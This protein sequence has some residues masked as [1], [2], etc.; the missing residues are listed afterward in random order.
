MTQVTL[1]QIHKY[2][3]NSP[4]NGLSSKLREDLRKLRILKEGDLEC[5]TYFHLRTFLACD[6]NWR[7]F[8][9]KRSPKTGR[10][11]D[12]MLYRGKKP[13]LAIEIKYDWDEPA[14]KDRTSLVSVREKLG[15]QK[16]YF[17]TTLPSKK[18]KKSPK[19]KSEKYRHFEVIVDLGYV[20]RDKQQK[21]KAFEEAR[22][23]FME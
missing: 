18:Y 4:T 2:L 19:R 13:Q 20:G 12:I 17:V 7:V 22:E 15:I 11:T 1:S 16:T 5:C 14:R 8:A 21:I 3:T 9:R 6:Q 10:Y 23:Q